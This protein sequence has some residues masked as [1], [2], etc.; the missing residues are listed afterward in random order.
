MLFKKKKTR[1]SKKELRAAPGKKL[2]D[3]ALS[4]LRE[5]ALRRRNFD[6]GGMRAPDCGEGK[7]LEHTRYGDWESKGRCSDF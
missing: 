1:I 3:A 5:A 2:R 6:S 4:A 7:K